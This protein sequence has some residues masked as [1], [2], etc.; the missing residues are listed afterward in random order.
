MNQL[1]FL[2]VL[3]SVTGL[4]AQTSRLG[5]AAGDV[6]VRASV[7]RSAVWVADRFTYN[8]ELTCRRGVDILPDDLSRDKLKLD[9][10]EILGVDSIR[11]DRGN[12]VTKY[13]YSYRLTTYK[14]DQ[15]TQ[16]I[17]GL[18]VR[19]YVKRP[20]QR[21]EDAT[22]AGDVQVPG[23]VVAVRSMLPDE[24]HTATF[25]DTLP[26]RPR[27][28]LFAMLQPVGLGLVIVSIVPAALW[29]TVLVNRARQRSARRSAR[30][31]RHEERESI[32]ALE[33]MDLSTEAGRLEA[34]DRVNTLVRSHL[35]DA[36]GVPVDGL[37]ASEVPP[38]LARRTTRVPAD[39]VGEVLAACERARY[40]GNG[41]GSPQD[42]RDTIAQAQQ[43]LSA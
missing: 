23:A 11:E 2:F 26:P 8:V 10:P 15:P 37:A 14:V 39:L 1:G 7:D 28:P 36:C 16:R 12:G 29:A 20:G 13:R 34:Y 5:D 9:G 42:C 19:Y 40:S 6:E 22:P 18:S 38:V 21:V 31:V 3:M 33:S 27:T 25:R 41:L 24:A 35:R 17:G 32:E 43:V 4:F 30:Q